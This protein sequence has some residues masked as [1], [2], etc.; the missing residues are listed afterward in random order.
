MG[1][2]TNVRTATD[3]PAMRRHREHES[4]LWDHYGLTP[5]ERWIELERPRVR[6]RV[7][8]VGEGRPVLCVGGTGGTGPYWGALMS[9]IEGVRWLALDRPG[10]GLS[11]SID[12]SK[13]D[14]ASTVVDVQRG[15]LDALGLERVSL[16]GHSIGNTWV[17][18]L[19]L[20]EPDRV[21]RV[22]LM[23][24]FPILD[25]EVPPFIKLLRTPLGALMVRMQQRRGMLEKMMRQTGHGDSLDAGRIPDAFVQWRLSIS[26]DTST[27]VFEREMVRA[28]V[29]RSGFRPGVALTDDQWAAIRQPVEVTWGAEDPAGGGTEAIWERLVGLVPDGRLHVLPGGG[30]L[31]WFDDPDQVA[32]WLG[33]FLAS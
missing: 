9:R 32:E 6:L 1:R 2:A 5:N 13:Q 28:I 11:E 25:D 7:N 19:A 15:V 22:A 14:F 24:G 8:E 31:P 3:S 18:R 33:A 16:L 21:E 17:L 27:M 12:W 20:A 23:G 30:H 10:F 26:N 4:A 29:D